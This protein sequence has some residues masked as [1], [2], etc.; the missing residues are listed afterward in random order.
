MIK[1]MRIGK[2]FLTAAVFLGIAIVT[3]DSAAAGSN[4][5][6]AIFVDNLNYVTAYPIGS[7]G[8]VAPIAVTSDMISPGGIARDA[9]GRIYV[10]NTPTNTVTI[11]AANANGNVPPLAVIGGPLTQLASPT[12]IALD[13]SGKIYVLDPAHR[14]SRCLRRWQVRELLTKLQ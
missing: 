10:T 9:A 12:G 11:Y 2:I 4:P 7:S 5:A 1:G 6:P 14:T 8:D 13:A 3:L